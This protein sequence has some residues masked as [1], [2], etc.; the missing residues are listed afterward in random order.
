MNFVYNKIGIG[1]M[2]SSVTRNKQKQEFSDTPSELDFDIRQL[3][4]DMIEMFK[5]V[6]DIFD[7][8]ELY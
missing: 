3:H 2:F 6:K 5:Q 8:L 4:I 7:S 1:S